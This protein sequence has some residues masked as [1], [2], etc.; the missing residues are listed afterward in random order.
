MVAIFAICAIA[1][2]LV[3][4]ERILKG[5]GI[6]AQDH[7]RLSIARRL[8]VGGTGGDFFLLWIR[9]PEPRPSADPMSGPGPLAAFFKQCIRSNDEYFE[10]DASNVILLVD[11]PFSLAPKVAARIRAAA[12]GR[13][14]PSFAMAS[15][16][17]PADG[18]NGDALMAA[19]QS[20]IDGRTGDPASAAPAPEPSAEPLELTPA[21]QKLIDPATGVLRTQYALLMSQKF[22]ARSHRRHQPVALVLA[23]IERWNDFKETYGVELAALALKE[24]AHAI[25]QVTRE[26]DLIGRVDDR[27]FFALCECPPE[28]AGA[29]AT[30]LCEAIGRISLPVGPARIRLI[31]NAG[32]ALMP[33]QAAQAS[34]LFWMAD[35]A[36]QRA[37]KIGPN[38][39]ALYDPQQP[40]A[41]TAPAPVKPTTFREKP[42]DIF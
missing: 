31:V 4:Y 20:K 24:T 11:A 16:A 9:I 14:W 15:A 7:V 28:K 38:Q 13:G 26:N 29:I 2:S 10:L 22:A 25:E 34:T 35:E 37:S 40:R 5:H 27:S 8:Q 21:E 23:G 19:A 42:S 30:R 36:R 6:D 41:T 3:K 12:A 39:W 18:L 33:T 32:V 17:V 1:L